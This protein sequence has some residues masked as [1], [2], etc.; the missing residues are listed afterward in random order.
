[1]VP[2]LASVPRVVKE[3]RVVLC[4]S[5]HEPIERIEDVLSISNRIAAQQHGSMAAWQHGE[6][7]NA[8]QHGNTDGRT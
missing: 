4:G 6:I 7:A 5:F 3:Q 2:D 1:M 8:R